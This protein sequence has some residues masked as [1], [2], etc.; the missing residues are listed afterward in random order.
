MEYNS[1]YSFRSL[2]SQLD[3]IKHV[4][5]TLAKAGALEI[6]E[7]RRIEAPQADEGQANIAAYRACTQA[8]GP[9]ARSGIRNPVPRR[10]RNGKCI[11]KKTA[12]DI[13]LNN[14]GTVRH[15]ARM[16]MYRHA[17]KR[18]CFRHNTDRDRL[19]GSPP[20]DGLSRIGSMA[21]WNSF[22]LPFLFLFLFYSF[23]ITDDIDRLIHFTAS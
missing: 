12:A 15:N 3:V 10:S 21:W 9:A 7:L 1:D 6:K 2:A 18:R 19:S 22:L 13:R 17:G 8:G 11:R 20:E 5:V 14:T 23:E 4:V 16:R